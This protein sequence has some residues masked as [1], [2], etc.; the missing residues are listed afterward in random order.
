M[1]ILMQ[2]AMP[3]I[4]MTAV[5]KCCLSAVFNPPFWVL[6]LP[7][8]KTQFL[9]FPGTHDTLAE[10]DT[11]ISYVVTGT[12]LWYWACWMHLLHMC[13]VYVQALLH[14]NQILKTW[15]KLWAQVK[16]PRVW[17]SCGD[18]IEKSHNHFS[19]VTYLIFHLGV[20]LICNVRNCSSLWYALC[21][22]LFS[23]LFQPTRQ[24]LKTWFNIIIIILWAINKKNKKI[25]GAIIHF[26]IVILEETGNKIFKTTFEFVSKK[27]YTKYA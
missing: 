18:S 2:R 19:S 27:R 23:W 20:A 22:G 4:C 16:W 15:W 17:C 1:V 9:S 7:I 6:F 8:L 14:I 13:N 10:S 24:I 5:F 26:H 12:A 11:A 21:R 25:M 3:L